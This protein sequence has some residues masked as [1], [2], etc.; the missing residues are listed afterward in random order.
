VRNLA[1]QLAANKG[2]AQLAAGMGPNHYFNND[3]F[4][5][6]H[7]LV[8]ALTDNIGHFSGN[9]GSYAGNYRGSMFQAM[10]QWIAED[11]FAIEADFTK[12]AAVKRYYKAESA[13]YWNYGD[14]PSRRRRDHHGGRAHADPG[15]HL[16]RNSNSLL[17]NANYPSTVKNTP[18]SRMR[19]SATNSLTSSCEY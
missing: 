13:H 17:G 9:V 14:R 19:S 16:V 5:R 8:A 11:P 3:L 15:T 12:P 18:R 10:G 2:N 1:R 7:F 4:G 6:V